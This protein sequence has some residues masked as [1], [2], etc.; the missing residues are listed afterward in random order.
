SLVPMV[1]SPPGSAT[2]STP[3]LVT[4]DAGSAPPPAPE[5]L[6]G[7]FSQPADRAAQTSATIMDTLSEGFTGYSLPGRG[8]KAAEEAAVVEDDENQNGSLLL[9]PS[10]V[11]CTTS[12]SPALE[13]SSS[14]GPSAETAK[15]SQ[16]LA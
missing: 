11:S 2:I 10:V 16:P 13:R 7:V 8:V 15:R 5:G 12:S 1:N 14:R 9:D 4:I 6:D 3:D